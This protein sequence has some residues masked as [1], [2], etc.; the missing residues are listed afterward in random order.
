MSVGHPTLGCFRKT[1]F[2]DNKKWNP[3]SISLGDSL[4]DPKGFLISSLGGG[5]SSHFCF[6]LFYITDFHSALSQPVHGRAE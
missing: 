3:P 1:L 5:A 6:D 2:N 4:K